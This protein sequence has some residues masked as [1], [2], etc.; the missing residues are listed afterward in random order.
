MLGI[1]SVVLVQDMSEFGAMNSEHLPYSSIKA[2]EI[3][4]KSKLQKKKC[5][6]VV[7]W[8]LSV[9]VCQDSF[10]CNNEILKKHSEVKINFLPPHTVF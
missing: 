7:Q 2:N 3:S 1:L 5:I 4:F 9:K 6:F 8:A 10:D